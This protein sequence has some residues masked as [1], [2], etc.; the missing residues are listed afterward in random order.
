MA[1]RKDGGQRRN[2][3]VER[4]RDGRTVGRR[5][6]DVQRRRGRE[7]NHRASETAP[8]LFYEILIGS[9]GIIHRGVTLV[10]VGAT[11]LED[12]SVAMTYLASL[13]AATLIGAAL[14][15]SPAQAR[16]GGGGGW[17]GGGWHGAS[18]RR[19]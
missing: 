3:G 9:N 7:Q 11:F 16:F 8:V 15:A 6:P 14:I 5:M 12:R 4:T 18:T 10:R 19:W 2:G 1:L 13:A 17:H